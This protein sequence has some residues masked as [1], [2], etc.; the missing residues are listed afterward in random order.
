M[1]DKE[2][3]FIFDMHNNASENLAEKLIY[4]L[5]NKDKYSELSKNA[6]ETALKYNWQD[7]CDKF[8]EVI[9]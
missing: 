9:Q 7:F 4:L 2:N 8:Y 6:Y 3:G 5:E 1:Q